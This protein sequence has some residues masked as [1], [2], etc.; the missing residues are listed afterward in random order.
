MTRAEFERLTGGTLIHLTPAE[1]ASGIVTNGLLSAA[2]L[3]QAAGLD[4][5]NVLLRAN[6]TRLTTPSGHALLTHQRPLRQGKGKDFLEDHTLESWSNQLDRR[7]FFWPAK[8]GAAFG[9]SLGATVKALRFNAGRVYDACAPHLWLSPINSGNATRRPA[10][11]GDWLYVPATAPLDTFRDNRRKRGLVASRDQ[12]AEVSLTR[13]LPA[14][15]LA[16]LMA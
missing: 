16:G 14:T 1:N 15:Q 12:L 5:D 6:P 7:I 10:R 3:A 9:N 4:P 13:P 2:D 11:R 8:R